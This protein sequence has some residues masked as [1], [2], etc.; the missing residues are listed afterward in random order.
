[1]RIHL[2][3]DD[4]HSML[5]YTIEHMISMA[6]HETTVMLFFSLH[7]DFTILLGRG[8]RQGLSSSDFALYLPL[9]ALPSKVG[10][11][12]LQPR[13]DSGPSYFLYSFRPSFS[14]VSSL[15]FTLARTQRSEDLVWLSNEV[16]MG[17]VW[18]S[19]LVF[20]STS[21]WRECLVCGSSS[22]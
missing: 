11:L 16:R 15:G 6:D 17:R 14:G 5:L 18:N 12:Q 21:G 22:A 13:T 1:M 2:L 8:D 7:C 19:G 9:L 20:S 10:R 4:D 3:F